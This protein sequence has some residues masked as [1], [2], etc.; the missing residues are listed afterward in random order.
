MNDILRLLNKYKK[1]RFEYLNRNFKM[2]VF[3]E[4]CFKYGDIDRDFLIKNKHLISKHWL[5]YYFWSI[6]IYKFDDIYSPDEI[7]LE[8]EYFSDDKLLSYL[9][10]DFTEERLLNCIHMFS[11]PYVEKILQCYELSSETNNTLRKL[12]KNNDRVITALNNWQHQ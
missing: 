1:D 4:E 8:D 9:K 12:Y 11:I 6:H 5:D 7:L 3:L 2:L 10:D